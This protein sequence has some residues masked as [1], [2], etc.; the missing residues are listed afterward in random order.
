MQL[1]TLDPKKFSKGHLTLK[2]IDYAEGGEIK[3]LMIGGL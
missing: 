1:L 2:S 3:N